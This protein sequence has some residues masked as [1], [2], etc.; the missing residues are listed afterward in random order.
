MPTAPGEPAPWF[1]APTPS[2]PEFVF[3][4][5]AGRY[6]L[7]AFLPKDDAQ[8]AAEAIR[9]LA[10]HQTMFDDD[11]FTAFV[12]VRDAA[13]A[14]SA[15]DMPGLRWFLDLDGAISRQFGTL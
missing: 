9:T 5:A 4:T 12:V 8:A 13:T 15:Q 6:V 3:D 2:N 11:R 1:K 7:M 14:A 10:A